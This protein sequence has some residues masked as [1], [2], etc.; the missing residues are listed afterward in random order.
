MHLLLSVGM[1]LS[2]V[3]LAMP[4][5]LPLCS[6]HCRGS[7]SVLGE[8][9]C[10]VRFCGCMCLRHLDNAHFF[11]YIVYISCYSR[12]LN[13]HAQPDCWHAVASLAMPLVVSAH[14]FAVC[15]LLLLSLYARAIQRIGM[16]IQ[17][18]AY[19][20]GTR[21]RLRLGNIPLYVE[22]LCWKAGVSSVYRT[23]THHTDIYVLHL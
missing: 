2:I 12:P 13:N 9:Y 14:L 1:L 19:S 8:L 21:T 18:V 5:L 4:S 23:I 17:R 10:G 11:T 6:A 20:V 7:C 15:V 16:C 3:H 22:L